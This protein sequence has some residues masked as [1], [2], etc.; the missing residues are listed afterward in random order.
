MK[1][2]Q[3]VLIARSYSSSELCA[4][5]VSQLLGGLI[6]GSKH[7]GKALVKL[8]RHSASSVLKMRAFPSGMLPGE[9]T[10]KLAVWWGRQPGSHGGAMRGS[11]GPSSL[12]RS[13][14]YPRAEEWQEKDM[15]K[16][17]DFQLGS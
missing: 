2:G 6:V 3:G 12:D 17:V 8:R 5:R 1:K 9:R 11:A 15:E 14:H 7:N 4:G 10:E 13:G 16:V